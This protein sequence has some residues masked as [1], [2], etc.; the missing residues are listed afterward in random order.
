MLISTRCFVFII[1]ALL[2]SSNAYAQIGASQNRNNSGSAIS[3]QSSTFKTD[4]DVKVEN[5]SEFKQEGGSS[6][7]FQDS[8]PPQQTGGNVSFSESQFKQEGGAVTVEDGSTLKIRN[9]N[10]P[11]EKA[12]A[13]DKSMNPNANK[14]G[15]EKDLQNARTLSGADKAV[16]QAEK[17]SKHLTASEQ[18]SPMKDNAND[19]IKQQAKHKQAYEQ[20]TNSCKK[21][22]EM[23]KGGIELN[24][25]CKEKPVPV[26]P[27]AKAG[28][29]AQAKAGYEKCLESCK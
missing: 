21:E 5:G 4:G 22:Y 7:E 1:S 23:V 15:F 16:G 19:F 11:N 17:T 14:A 29:L 20:C 24:Y 6:V 25:P 18:D 8:A 27:P 3:F 28:K 2:A 26:C 12:I 13:G 10:R 9:G